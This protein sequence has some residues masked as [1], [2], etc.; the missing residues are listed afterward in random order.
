VSPRW[1]YEEDPAR[2]SEI[3]VIF[4]PEGPHVT[5]VAFTHRHLERYGAQAERMRQI[6]DEKGGGPLTAFAAHFAAGRQADKR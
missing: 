2:G 1:T 5:C 3:E 6:L 4:T